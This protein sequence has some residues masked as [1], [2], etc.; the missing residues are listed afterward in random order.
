MEAVEGEQATVLL[1]DHG[2][3][4]HVAASELRRLT[5]HLGA[6]GLVAR[7]GLAG[8]RPT[9]GAW[10]TE[11][12]KAAHI[13]L[14]VGEDTPLQVEVVGEQ[15]GIA[16]VKIKDEENNDMAELLVES[17]LALTD[18]ALTYG[19][20][21]SGPLLV[22]AAASPTDLHLS[23][24]ELFKVFSDEVRLGDIGSHRN[25]PLHCGQV[26]PGVQAAGAGGEV[27]EQTAV[28]QRL[29]AHDGE[30]WWV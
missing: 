18:A 6:P 26:Y 2:Q 20:L 14:G 8:V 5:R 29:L 1:V 15:G 9:A 19:E 12:V 10:T 3:R 28:G 7:C 25:S 4:L 21:S 24:P 16:M 23:S 22:F 30:A 27:P 17:G 11:E 13:L